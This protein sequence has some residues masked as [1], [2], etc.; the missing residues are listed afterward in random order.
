LGAAQPRPQAPEAISDDDAAAIAWVSTGG[1]KGTHAQRIRPH[2]PAARRALA[3]GARE[4]LRRKL[5]EMAAREG[6]A[7][8]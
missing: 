5:A 6:A 4:K 1:R 8:D 2:D 3:D 7:R